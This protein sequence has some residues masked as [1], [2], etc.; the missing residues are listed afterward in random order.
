[1]PSAVATLARV[2]EDVIETQRLRLRPFA[3]DLSDLDALHEIQSDA[4]HMRFYPHPF[5]REESR[6]WIE[7]SLDRQERL[8]YSLWA[9][10][11]RETREFLGNCGPIPQVV[12]GIEEVELGWS[13]TPRRAREGIASEAA[14]AWRDRCLGPLGMDHVISLIRPENAP[15]RGVAERIG[16]TVWK[17]TLHGGDRWLHLVYRVDAARAA[18]PA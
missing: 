14:E 12:D 17:D 7:R 18:E 2:V 6:A 8:G 11:D 5:S 1:L 10:E 9:I 15:S 13:V 4:H 16:M 3:P